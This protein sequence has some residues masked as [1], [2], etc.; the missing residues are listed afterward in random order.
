ME[1][2]T[3]ET[4]SRSRNDYVTPA[5]LRSLLKANLGLN[6]RKVTVSTGSSTTYLTITIRDAGVDIAA[7]K[8]FASK[9]NTWTIDNTD[10]CEGQS[11]RVTTTREVD[12]THAAPHLEEIR[13]VVAR[14]GESSI[15][16]LS[17][18]KRLW[19]CDREF[20]VTANDDRDRGCYI[21]ACA[22]RAGEAYAIR[23]LA[24]QMARV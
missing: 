22:V 7:V 10:Y 6:A 1:T 23:A 20:H 24:L 4:I 11:V 19:S 14:I 8:A 9:F 15:E 12:D 3:L 17:N 21:Q 2:N 13:A 5:E 18:G 16:T